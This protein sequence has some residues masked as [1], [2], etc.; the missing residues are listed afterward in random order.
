MKAH[1]K[2]AAITVIT[3]LVGIYVIRKIPV[4]GPLADTALNG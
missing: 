4:V 2:A 3:V 1:L